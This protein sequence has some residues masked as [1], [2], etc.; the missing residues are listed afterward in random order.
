MNASDSASVS[1]LGFLRNQGVLKFM[2]AVFLAL[3]ACGVA[4]ADEFFA[5]ISEAKD[6]KVTFKKGD[7]TAQK[8]RIV[9]NI[10]STLPTAHD[11]KVVY[12]K[13]N[14]QG[15][16]IEA[17]DPI[18]QGLKNEMFNMTGKNTVLFATVITDKNNETIVEIRVQIKPPGEKKKN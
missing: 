14:K 10:E 11:V 1:R 15:G 9:S 4:M 2:C 8:K 3:A 16:G 5:I 7:Q 18:P 12:A 13:L 6:G 17:G